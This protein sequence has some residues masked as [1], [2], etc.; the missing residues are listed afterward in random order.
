V[1]WR[2]LRNYT[3]IHAMKR[4][5]SEESREVAA[6]RHLFTKATRYATIFLSNRLKLPLQAVL[7]YDYVLFLKSG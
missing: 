6:F 7:D 3:S 5:S 1:C 2:G 4:L